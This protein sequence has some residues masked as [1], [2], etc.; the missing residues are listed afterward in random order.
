MILNA[1][2]IYNFIWQGYPV[3]IVD[4]TDLN[5]HFHPFGLSACKDE[6][7]ALFNFIFS[8]ININLGKLNESLFRPEVLVSDAAVLYGKL[9]KKFLVKQKWLCA[10]NILT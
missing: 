9:M 1:D 3:L 7:T 8:S 10:G 6:K 4:T 5:N 2:A